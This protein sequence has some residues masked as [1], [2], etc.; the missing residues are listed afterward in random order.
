MTKRKIEYWVIPPQANAEFV[1]NMEEVLETYEKAYDPAHPVLCMDEQPVQL[2]KETRVPIKATKE[3]GERVDYEYERNGTASIF[4][5]AEPLSG[6]RQATARAQRTKVEWALEVAAMLD[7]RYADCEV[8]T[9]VLDKLNTH[10]KGAFYEAFDPDKA[11]AYLRRLHF[12]YTPK[13]GSWLKSKTSLSIRI[14]TS[15]H[16]I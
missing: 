13:H 15:R 10:T 12:C 5:F 8:V 2:L 9:L 3:H 11:R 7:T 4:M 1:A 16:S 14:I 6:Y